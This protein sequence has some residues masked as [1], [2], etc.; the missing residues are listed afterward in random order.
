MIP[1]IMILAA[2]FGVAMVAQ[3]EK[4]KT[5]IEYRYELQNEN[6]KEVI[7]FFKEK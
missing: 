6:E 7:N 2:L 1:V 3:H 4:P 5:K